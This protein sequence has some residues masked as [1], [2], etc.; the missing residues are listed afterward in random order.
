M[1]LVKAWR[2]AVNIFVLI[3]FEIIC[4]YM[5]I[6]THIKK[7]SYAV[8]KNFSHIKKAAMHI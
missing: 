6:Y 2:K 8:I 3:K 4:V 1:N 5:L 7:S